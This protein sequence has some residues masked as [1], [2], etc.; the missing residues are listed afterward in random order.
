MQPIFSHCSKIVKT[1]HLREINSDDSARDA[2]DSPGHSHLHR[3]ESLFH[4]L[5]NIQTL[6]NHCFLILFDSLNCILYDKITC[7]H[8]AT[9]LHVMSSHCLPTHLRVS[10]V[11]SK[12]A[13]IRRV[14][15][16]R[17]VKQMHL[18]WELCPAGPGLYSPW[19]RTCRGW[20]LH[21]P[22]NYAIVGGNSSTG[23]EKVRVFLNAIADQ[24]QNTCLLTLVFINCDCC[25]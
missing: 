24:Q 9:D 2:T 13:K 23:Q 17:Q 8:R 18:L 3:H 21:K 19:Q 14:Q 11:Q 12:F 1:T 25:I 10:S 5:I 15:S 16:W 20:M 7:E 4:C 22:R 6:T